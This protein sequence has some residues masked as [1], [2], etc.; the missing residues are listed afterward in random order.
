MKISDR[1]TDYALTGGLFWVLQLL[2]FL[3]SNEYNWKDLLNKWTASFPLMPASST[4]LLGAA[5]LIIVFTTGMFL[6]V[7]GSWIFRLVEITVFIKRLKAHREWIDPI[8]SQSMAYIQYDY[9]VLYRMYSFEE[10]F[11]L[12]LSP[13]DLLRY[14]RSRMSK[15]AETELDLSTAMNAFHRIQSLLSS[16]LLLS[17]GV[18]KVESLGSQLSLWTTARAFGASLVAIAVELLIVG[19]HQRLA[20]HIGTV[21]V[22]AITGLVSFSIPGGAYGR[23]CDTLFAMTFI[24]AERDKAANVPPS[25]FLV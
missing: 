13:R 21:M 23:L 2:V 5:G 10:F 4:A 17:S 9:T 19:D 16:R 1:F 25:E 6:D 15:S 11:V 14:L 8:L 3:I 22:A 24:I 12:I 18:E 7:L 20:Y